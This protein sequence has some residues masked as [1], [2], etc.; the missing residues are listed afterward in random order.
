[1]LS[2]TW[3]FKMSAT[4]QGRLESRPCNLVNRTTAP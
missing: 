2:A 3:V 1:M 4:K